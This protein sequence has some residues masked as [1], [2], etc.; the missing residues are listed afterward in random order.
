MLLLRVKLAKG[1]A[2]SHWEGELYVCILPR[3]KVTASPC[4]SF[5][6]PKHRHIRGRGKSHCRGG[7][8]GLLMYGCKVLANLQGKRLT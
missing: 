1:R 4:L 3:W 2:V 5:P 7:L 8:A 6:C